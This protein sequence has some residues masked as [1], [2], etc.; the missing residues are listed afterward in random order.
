MNPITRTLA[1]P[2]L[3]IALQPA[4]AAQ[5][6]QPAKPGSAAVVAYTASTITTA[7]GVQ[8][9]YKDWGP[10]DGPVVTFSHGWPLSSDSWESQ[11]LFLASEGYRVVAHDRRGHGRSSQPWEGNDMDHY[12]DDLA[13][14][15]D[16]LDLQDVTL[17]GFSTGGGE[18]ARYIGRHGTGRVKK[19]VL[20]SAVP[21]MML[22]TEDNPDGLPLEV[23]DGIRKASLED[24]AQLYLDLASGPFYGFNRPGAKVSQGLIDNWRAQGMQAGHKNTY[25]SI[26]AF[27]ATDF[28]EDLKKF[29]VPTLVIHGDDDQI[30]PLDISG[31][32]S[33]AQIKDAKLIVY[34]GAPHGLTDTHKA[35]FNQ[36]LLDFLRK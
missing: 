6:A 35:R 22:R 4:F 19:A 24:R 28:R 10:K 1:M 16:A 18:V 3:A 32:A 21:P 9:Y 8:L 29:D 33:A 11:M 14:V 17:V 30:V 7:D 13:A 5:A 23:F 27:S 31:K 34:P 26:A 12:A 15:I 2:L 36:D 20:V 25:D